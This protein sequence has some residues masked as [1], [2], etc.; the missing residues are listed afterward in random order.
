MITIVT[1]HIIGVLL[2]VFIFKNIGII[3]STSGEK[4]MTFLLLIGLILF[5]EYQLFRSVKH[6]VIYFKGQVDDFDE[7]RFKS[8]QFS[9]AILG[10]FTVVILLQNLL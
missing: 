2:P 7:S 1:G 10:G 6:G 9:Y 5:I 4:S 8:C 3:G